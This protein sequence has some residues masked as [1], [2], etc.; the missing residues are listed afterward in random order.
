MPTNCP[1]QTISPSPL[2]GVFLAHSE[3]LTTTRAGSI[4]EMVAYVQVGEVLLA[5]E[6]CQ[7]WQGLYPRVKL[8]PPDR[9]RASSTHLP[10]KRLQRPRAGWVTTSH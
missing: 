4:P 1:S 8:G 5:V 10:Q 6:S 2:F 7:A 3:I 9:S